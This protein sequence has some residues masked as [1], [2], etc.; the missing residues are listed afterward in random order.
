MDTPQDNGDSL[1]NAVAAIEEVILRSSGMGAKPIVEKKKRITVNGVHHEIDVYVTANFH[2]ATNQFSF[3][4]ARIGK[5]LWARMKSSSF[6][7]K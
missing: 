3:L 5:K 7:K 4:S 1:E 2:P 6:P